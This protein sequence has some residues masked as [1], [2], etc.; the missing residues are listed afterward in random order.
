MPNV[1]PVGVRRDGDE[2]LRHC[3]LVAAETCDEPRPGAAGVRHRL[4]RGERLRRDDEERLR[5]VEIAGR[6]GEIGAVHVGHESGRSARARC[7]AGAPRRPSPG[8][9]SEPPIPMLTTLRIRFP[10]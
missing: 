3:R 6:L 4:E 8:P 9:R 5:R 1:Y 10:V 2:V 7:S